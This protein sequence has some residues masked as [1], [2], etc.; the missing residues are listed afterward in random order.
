MTG[1]S[2][3]LPLPNCDVIQGKGGEGRAFIGVPCQRGTATRVKAKDRP[4]DTPF[5]VPIVGGP[6]AEW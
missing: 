5:A 4:R 1:E 3:Y 2:D 6:T